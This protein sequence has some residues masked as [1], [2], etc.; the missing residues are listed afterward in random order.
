[1]ANK[2]KKLSLIVVLVLTSLLA[3]CANS[4]GKSNGGNSG[5]QPEG[6]G[7]TAESEPPYEVVMAYMSGTNSPDLEL[8]QQEMSKITKQKI[9][10]TIKLLPIGF[11]AWSQQTNLM[12]SGSEKLDLMVTGSGF[13]YSGQVSK[14]QLLPLDDLLESHGQGILKAVDPTYLEGS[15]IKGELFGVTGLREFAADWGAV[16]RKD[17]VDKHNIDL[18]QVTTWEQLGSVLE[19]IKQNE[20]GLTPLGQQGQNQTILNVM[21]A[22][23]FDT[24]GDG[25]GV[26]RYSGGTKL[27]NLYE[28]QEYLDALKLVRKWNQAGY[29]AKDLAIS[30][31]TGTNLVKAN[32][33]FGYVANL[34]PGF[35]AQETRNSSKEIV[36]LRLTKPM[37]GAGS[38]NAFMMSITKNSKN[39][40]KAMEM[41]NL[42]YTDPELLNLL[43]WGIEGKHY[44]KKGDNMIGQP[45]GVSGDTGY[46]FFFWEIG[47]AF[48]TYIWEG[49]D[50][51]V[52]EK[53]QVFNESAVKS[54][55]IGFTFSADAVKTEIASVTNVLNQYRVALETGTVDPVK[56]LPE[57][58]AKLKEAGL[59][60]IIAE[61]QKQYD[62]WLQSK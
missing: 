58:N 49:N 20:P 50:P 34:K 17:I 56:T 33:L 5:V 18:S 10:A 46:S 7:Q 35:E 27:E 51:Q 4:D 6:N 13:N 3:A 19:T 22:D 21:M 59:E 23:K 38:F 31:D 2:L 53:T 16:F 30:T 1:M 57:F 14:G 55:A 47:N 24:L 62:A 12:L 32:K 52:W 41:M 54:P 45:S 61:K 40:E 43:D 25:F 26:I 8:V 48:I 44:E 11:A 15:R 39:P 42:L 28:S 29:L 9:N 36:G 60:K 37:M